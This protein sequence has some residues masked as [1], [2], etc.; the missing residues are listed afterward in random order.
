M[1]ATKIVIISPILHEIKEMDGLAYIFINTL[2]SLTADTMVEKLSSVKI[3]SEAPFCNIRTGLPHS[4]ADV[5]R[6]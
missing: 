1:N 3:K 2:P 5:C 4:A 6:F